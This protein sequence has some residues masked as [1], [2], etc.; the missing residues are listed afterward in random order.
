MWSFHTILIS[1]VTSPVT[2]CFELF[3]YNI[4]G[5]PKDVFKCEE[6]D[7]DSDELL[8][9]DKNNFWLIQRLTTNTKVERLQTKNESNCKSNN[10]QNNLFEEFCLK[11]ITDFTT[12]TKDTV[13]FAQSSENC[14]WELSIKE[15]HIYEYIGECDSNCV[16]EGC[17]KDGSFTEARLDRPHSMAIGQT[18]D[19][20]YI[21]DN[22]GIRAA[23]MRNKMVSCLA[24]TRTN[25]PYSIVYLQNTLIEV[26]STGGPSEINLLSEDRTP[27]SLGYVGEI[28]RSHSDMLLLLSENKTYVA[29]IDTESPFP[30][31]F[32]FPKAISSHPA[33]LGM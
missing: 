6:L 23:N 16:N 32:I 3:S 25:R 2:K 27:K 33:T 15:K 7:K 24:A 4:P 13:L 19:V 21:T 17:Y 11:G 26:M 22:N 1:F 31:R 10:G 30:F 29:L 8:C 18:N 14:I 20:L 12:Q 9:A 28:S 5:F